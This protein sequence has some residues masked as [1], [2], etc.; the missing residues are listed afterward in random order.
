[1]FKYEQVEENYRVLK[2]FTHAYRKKLT[3]F[4]GAVGQVSDLMSCSDYVKFNNKLSDDE[5]IGVMMFGLLN[6]PCIDLCKEIL[7][8]EKTFEYLLDTYLTDEARKIYD[9]NIGE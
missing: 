8:S 5:Y 1:M 7:N 3:V 2:E 4:Q 6:E 9:E